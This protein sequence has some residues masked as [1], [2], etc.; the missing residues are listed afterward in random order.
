[1]YQNLYAQLPT[2]VHT[3]AADLAEM[4]PNGIYD[5]KYI[6]DYVCRKE[7]SFLEYVFRSQQRKNIVR[8]NGGKLPFVQLEFPTTSSS[9]SSYVHYRG[10]DHEPLFASFNPDLKLCSSFFSNHGHCPEGK[11][12]PMSHDIDQIV[13][14]KDAN[15]KKNERKRK[16]PQ[17]SGVESM[18]ELTDKQKAALDTLTDHEVQM[19]SKVNANGGSHRAGYDAFMT[20]F[21][22][23][24]FLVHSVIM[25]NQDDE[26]NGSAQS[27]A[28]TYPKSRLLG[29]PTT[30]EFTDLNITNRIYLV[31]KDIPF[32]IRKSAYSRNSVDHSNKYTVLKKLNN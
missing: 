4:F 28:Y 7:A 29:V 30:P 26:N 14:S 25:V 23:A 5:T 13:L 9:L 22:F 1:M 8:A 24:T 27:T 2:T 3:F 31:C 6:S 21:S 11:K 20:G 32:I 15:T 18:D 19:G 10:W 12:C 16:R 17:D